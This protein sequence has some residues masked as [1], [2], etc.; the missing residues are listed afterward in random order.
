M[1]FYPMLGDTPP[2]Q[3]T[4]QKISVQVAFKAKE[5]VLSFKPIL[6]IQF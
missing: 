2:A 3:L 1:G 6:Y 5:L 4:L